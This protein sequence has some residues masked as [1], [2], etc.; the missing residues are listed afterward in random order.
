MAQGPRCQSRL[1]HHPLTSLS[2]GVI[3]YLVTKLWSP[4]W[5]LPVGINLRPWQQRC[6]FHWNERTGF[7][8]STFNV[9]QLAILGLRSKITPE[10]SCSRELCQQKENKKST[11]YLFPNPEEMVQLFPRICSIDHDV[12]TVTSTLEQ[13]TFLLSSYILAQMSFIFFVSTYFPS[14]TFFQSSEFF[15]IT[16][17]FNAQLNQIRNLTSI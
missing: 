2:P 7:G 17:L 11:F 14:N 3:K 12:H 6:S 1:P 16:C 8:T 15:L 13:K 10:F 4:S 9:Q 5:D